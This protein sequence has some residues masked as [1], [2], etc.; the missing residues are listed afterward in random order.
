MCEKADTNFI[1][2]LHLTADTSEVFYVGEGRPSRAKDK[3]HRNRWWKFKVEKH[4]FVPH[5]IYKNL[6]KA[7][8][9]QLEIEIIDELRAAGK[10]LVNISYG[11]LYKGKII[12]LPKE[13]H[14]MYGKRFKAPWISESN[15]RRTGTKM[16]PRP[17]L[18]ERNRKRAKQ[19]ELKK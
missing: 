13:T 9:E 14:P 15:R 17:D 11:P 12:G 5:I 3:R 8:A 18:A 10:K 16:K 2:Y 6:T 7:E 1:V 19:K 4:G